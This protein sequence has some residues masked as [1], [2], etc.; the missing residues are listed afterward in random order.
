MEENENK[1]LYRPKRPKIKVRENLD[2]EDHLISM[3]EENIEYS[4]RKN[5]KLNKDIVLNE[6]N[7]DKI[8]KKSVQNKR[9]AKKPLTEFQKKMK[10]LIIKIDSPSHK[11]KYIF[12]KW[13]SLTFG[14]NN[15][16]VGDDDDEEE[17]EEE[18]EKEENN[19]ENIKVY[20]MKKVN[21][22]HD[23]NKNKKY[24]INAEQEEEEDEEEEDDKINLMN[25]L[26][27]NLEEI[28]E[29]PP[30]E[31]E[32]AMTSV[33]A[34]GRNP[35]NQINVALRKIFKY[36]NTF[37]CYFTK[38]K[39]V[40]G[41]PEIMI[42]LKYQKRLKNLVMKLDGK[43]NI[44]KLA[45]AF[46]N[47][48]MKC[49]QLRLNDKKYKKKKK[50]IIYKKKNGEME[51]KDNLEDYKNLISNSTNDNLSIQKDGITI[52]KVKKKIF[53]KKINSSK[54]KNIKT[55]NNV[56]N[57]DS[58]MNN[59]NNIIS[60]K[61]SYSSQDNFINL[62]K[63]ESE[64]SDINTSIS[65][66]KNDIEN[67]DSSIKPKKV[68][69]KVKKIV[70]KVKKVKKDDKSEKNENNNNNL[71]KIQ[72]KDRSKTEDSLP[73]ILIS[74][75]QIKSLIPLDSF[76]KNDENNK[77]KKMVSA[78]VK[79]IKIK[80]KIKKI[81]KLSKDDIN[82]K[83]SDLLLERKNELNNLKK[84]LSKSYNPK[85][86]VIDDDK[87]INSEKKSINNRN[88]S[89][90]KKT[91]KSKI[92]EKK[93]EKEKKII[94]E[95]KNT[96]QNEEN[97][98][99]SNEQIRN[100]QK[101]PYYSIKERVYKIEKDEDNNNN[102]NEIEKDGIQN[103]NSST[104]VQFKT[105][106]ED[107]LKKIDKDLF[108]NKGKDSKLDLKAIAS[109][110]LIDF[111]EEL[112]DDDAKKVKKEKTKKK[113]KKNDEQILKDEI[114]P[115]IINI[116][117]TQDDDDSEEKKKSKRKKKKFSKEE[118]ELIKKYKKAF[119]LLRK[120][121]RSYK[122]RN[123]G[124]KDKIGLDVYFNIWRNYIKN[125]FI[126]KNKNKDIENILGEKIDFYKKEKEGNENLEEKNIE[127]ENGLPKIKQENK[128]EEIKE[129]KKE[130]KEPNIIINENIIDIKNKEKEED[131]KGNDKENKEIITNNNDIK[132]DDKKS[133]EN[134]IN[135]KEPNGIEENKN[136][137]KE[138]FESQKNSMLNTLS[139]VVKSNYEI[140]NETID[141]IKKTEEKIFNRINLEKYIE[142]LKNNNKRIKAYQIFCLFANFSEESNYCMKNNNPKRF[143][144]NIWNRNINK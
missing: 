6:D 69:K 117:I 59:I 138:N 55:D 9:R 94:E 42:I 144:F 103:Q 125:N 36:K 54:S 96:G 79:K 45:I 63:K 66:I 44:L 57:N 47:W 72:D 48:K 80:K 90:K 75:D 19:K 112:S 110:D 27:N 50:I 73:S 43:R 7:K 99:I 130:E 28:E 30:N 131:N 38:W 53:K 16:N 92:K 91:Y 93:E 39:K 115:D 1:K 84:I 126:I 37:Y 81:K 4:N 21:N 10:Y 101:I 51:I 24:N 89:K 46:K 34:I 49:E 111:S 141:I 64:K 60:I 33:A 109:L 85:C 2:N 104:K 83:S 120:A 133:N 58:I 135:E 113:I 41:N 78:S 98:N 12:H 137:I 140:Q 15:N 65:D 87:S 71:E 105:D 123:G 129:N 139:D 128:I 74:S 22:F 143:Y 70:K 67:D 95:S 20:K 14:Q 100:I 5:L 127:K 62:N 122:K 119:H 102:N 56:D 17:E 18:I 88:L 132:I 116:E 142:F 52:K 82:N 114:N 97:S 11:I 118:K 8:R 13:V 86:E 31:E 77:E 136:E 108:Q 61:D 68:V 26:N 40:T 134:N 25:D 121:I 23:E 124:K 29:R 32:S 106:E 107:N 35:K 76:E 3:T